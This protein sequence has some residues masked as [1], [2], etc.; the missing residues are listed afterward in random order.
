MLSNPQL[1]IPEITKLWHQQQEQCAQIMDFY[2][3]NDVV[4]GA[5]WIEHLAIQFSDRV[6]IQTVHKPIDTQPIITY[7]K[8]NQMANQLSHY[9]LSDCTLY[10][11]RAMVESQKS[12]TT[13]LMTQRDVVCLLMENSEYF[14]PTWAGLNKLGLTVANINTYLTPDRM[15]HS[16]E[17]S[18][19]AAI[20][21]SRKMLPLFEKARD[22]SEEFEIKQRRR[23]IKDFKVF[24]VDDLIDFSNTTEL[25]NPNRSEC[26]DTVTGEDPLFYIYTSG[27][28]GKSKAARFSNRR[29]IGAGVTWSIQMDLTKDDNYYITLPLYHGNGGVVAVSAIM[30]V[31]GV[32]VLREKFSAS[33]FLPDI[34][35]FGCT[36][37]IYIG[38]LWRYMYNTPEKEDD[39]D[40][41]LRVAA[42]NG[43]RKDIWDNV[44][45]RFGIK[46][47]VEHYGQTEMVS[48]DPSVD[49]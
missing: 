14:I 29:F 49:S 48:I 6:A 9:L 38:E 8:V 33:N 19:A 46:K 3:K 36:A 16:I 26:R 44:V 11:T 23:F 13:H 17:L 30:R 35:K 27:T 20:F 1:N 47:I 32:C 15:K 25:E 43:L 7:A 24:V 37:T 2:K 39:A 41:P 12:D 5:D 18:G 40:N 28:T 4:T 34:R 10:K 22:E 42:G 21:V 31:G 45:S